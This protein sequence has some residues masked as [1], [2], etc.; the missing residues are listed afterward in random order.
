VTEVCEKGEELKIEVSNTV[1][2]V[3]R[4]TRRGDSYYLLIPKH[5]VKKI[6]LKDKDVVIAIISKIN[7]IKLLQ[8]R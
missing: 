5:Y 4:I 8:K 1:E 2:L 7:N 3:S 6:G